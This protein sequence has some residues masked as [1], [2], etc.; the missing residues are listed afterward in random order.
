MFTDSKET[1]MKSL[2]FVGVALL[3][4]APFALAQTSALN[5]ATLDF[6]GIG[7]VR[8][9]MNLSQASAAAKVQIK[10]EGAGPHSECEYAAPVSGP[11]GVGFTIVNQRIA[12]I[13]VRE[14]HFATSA[15][16]RV[17]DLESKVVDTYKGKA[18]FVGRKAVDSPRRLKLMTKSVT[19]DNMEM[20]FIAYGGKIT[21]IV[22]G[23]PVSDVPGKGCRLKN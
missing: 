15:G 23:R 12:D 1:L 10:S 8:V 20:T 5:S 9:G 6:E 2:R 14:G 18:Q 11:G 17:G 7:P 13:T 3:F 16:I 4:M 19:G 21:M 22:A